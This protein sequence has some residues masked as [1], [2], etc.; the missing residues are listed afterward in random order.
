MAGIGAC[1]IVENAVIVA[2]PKQ[3]SAP[4]PS[5]TPS[6]KDREPICKAPGTVNRSSAASNGWLPPELCAGMVNNRFQARTSLL[7]LS[8]DTVL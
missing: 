8:I 6:G 2:T 7:T 5:T 4:A 3:A 1:R